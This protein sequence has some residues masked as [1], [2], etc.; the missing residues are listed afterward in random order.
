MG[1]LTVKAAERKP[2]WRFA[3]AILAGGGIGPFHCPYFCLSC[4][5]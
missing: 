3:L 5:L 1:V 4:F 2:F